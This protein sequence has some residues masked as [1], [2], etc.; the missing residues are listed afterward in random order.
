VL[1]EREHIAAQA[2]SASVRRRG[3]TSG[4]RSLRATVSERL[5]SHGVDIDTIAWDAYRLDDGRWSVSADYRWGESNRHATFTFDARGRFSVASNDEARWLLGEQSAAKGPQPGRRRPVEDSD[6]AE[7]N[8]PTLDLSD[9]L[10]LVRAIQDRTRADDRDEEDE[11]EPT[12]ALPRLLRPVADLP[13][14]LGGDG[15]SEDSPRVYSG[16]SDASAVPPTASTAGWEPAIV[17]DYPVEPS[18]RIDPEPP[19]RPGEPSPE[20]GHPGPADSTP[21]G[22]DEPGPP[23]PTVSLSDRMD[24]AHELEVEA[25]RPHEPERKSIRRKRA[26]VPSWDEIMFGGPKRTS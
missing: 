14:D 26:S 24:E 20:A 2:M 25:T 9:D 13:P 7:D 16:L 12:V 19:V 4:H 18:L 1:A 21:P 6:S 10:A 17:V 23:D 22:T 5:L 8:E 3:E 11:E 15:Y